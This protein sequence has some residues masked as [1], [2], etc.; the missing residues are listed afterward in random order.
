MHVSIF[1]RYGTPRG[2]FCTRQIWVQSSMPPQE[3]ATD[4]YQILE[5]HPEEHTVSIV[6]ANGHL[7]H[8]DVQSTSAFN[9]IPVISI[10]KRSHWRVAL[11]SIA[12][13]LVLRECEIGCA[14]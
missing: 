6:A 12:T 3:Q 10:L 4:I 11:V 14:P 1:V 2:S 5:E 7:A 13:L 8:H 9:A